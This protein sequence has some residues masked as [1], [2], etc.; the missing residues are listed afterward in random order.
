MNQYTY[1]KH[2]ADGL[3]TTYNTG[4]I[5][6]R[7]VQPS[8]PIY[9]GIGLQGSPDFIGPRTQLHQSMFELGQY[10]ASRRV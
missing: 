8:Q 2:H 10:Y 5:G 7:N 6:P 1:E 4:T 9:H 3:I